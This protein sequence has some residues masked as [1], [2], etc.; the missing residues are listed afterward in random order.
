MKAE[1]ILENGARFKGELFGSEKETVGE[2]V[3]TT[4]MTGYQE[5]ITDPS[6]TGKIVTMTF[7]LVGNYGVNS[8]DM[9]SDKAYMKALI[10]REVCDFPSNFR[11]E[12]KLADFMKENGVVGLSGIDTRELTKIIRQ[13]GSMRGAIVIGEVS[14]AEA[15]AKIDAIDNSK[16]VMECT[17]KESYVFSDKGEK[18]IAYID[19]GT[20]KSML[21]ALAD[22]NCKVTVYPANVKADEIIASNPDAVFV[23]SGP[24]DVND[25][26]ETVETVK[27]LIGKLPIYGICLGHHV[28]SLA[29]GGVSEKMKFG[30][31]GGNHPVKEMASGRVFIT[32]QSHDFVVSGFDED[33]EITFKNV[34]D[35]SC[36]G[37]RHKKYQIESV[38]F[39]PESSPGPLDTTFI[40]DRFLGKED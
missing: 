36:E 35:G 15:K 11:C 30:H 12:N 14:D 25:I 38:Q 32:S 26:P 21:K 24:G 10:V 23:S 20:R 8:I 33:V 16:L 2:V 40:F 29:L 1:L 3:F 17:C 6:S 28:I 19:L 34:N 4:G 18:H 7:P 27:A 37:I 9:E 22:R 39:H 31:H 13:N 5:S